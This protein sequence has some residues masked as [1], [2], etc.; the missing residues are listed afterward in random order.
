MTWMEVSDRYR[1]RGGRLGRGAIVN[2]SS[3]F[4]NSI[5]P[6]EMGLIP[7]TTAK[8]GMLFFMFL[9]GARLT[10]NSRGGYHQI[11]TLP[12]PM[13]KD[14]TNRQMSI[15]AAK[16]YAAEGIRINAICPKSAIHP[17]LSRES[18]H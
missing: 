14:A 3:I 15:Q 11:R 9:F 7:Y 5:P 17:M 13:I 6:T 4:G 8:H 12:N 18:P 10:Q 2:L 1:D 16:A